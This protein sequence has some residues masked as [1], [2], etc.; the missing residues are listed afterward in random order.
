MGNMYAEPRD[1][2]TELDAKRKLL[3]II[4]LIVFILTF[5]PIPLTIVS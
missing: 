4:G 5:T 1:D 2:I 3:A